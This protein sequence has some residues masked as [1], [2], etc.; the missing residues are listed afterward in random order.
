M[1]EEFYFNHAKDIIEYYLKNNL[2]IEEIIE[3]LEPFNKRNLKLIFDR[4]YYI[5]THNLLEK[6]LL[7]S[8]EEIDE[9]K[10][11]EIFMNK[12]KRDFYL[13]KNQWEACVFYYKHGIPFLPYDIIENL[14]NRDFIDGGAHIGDF[15][16]I[17]EKYFYP[18]KIFAFEPEKSNY[19]LMLKTIKR[20]KLK[21]VIP[22]QKGLGMSNC[23]LKLKSQESGSFISENGDQEIEIITLDSYVFTENLNVGLIKLDVEGFALEV[24]KGAKE[25]IKK[26][27]PVLLIGNYHSGSEFFGALDFIRKIN[28]NYKILIKKLNPA[29]AF[30]ET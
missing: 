13:P 18:K 22:I 26:F 10:K 15:A 12:V 27:K 5:Y 28:L 29:A 21:K 19:N 4:I 14:E 1:R 6:N 20:N 23:H 25:T 30:L 8:R 7:F 17:F 24:L 16:L 11:I 2:H 3:D 9:K